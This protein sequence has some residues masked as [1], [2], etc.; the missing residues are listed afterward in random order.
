MSTEISLIISIISLVISLFS[1]A[2]S[3]LWI[4]LNFFYK[5]K[6]YVFCPNLIVYFEFNEKDQVSYFHIPLSIINK[7]SRIIIIN[8]MILYLI[9]D[10][11]GM[12]STLVAKKEKTEW[13]FK[14][15]SDLGTYIKENMIVPFEIQKFSTI[16]E[17]FT[18]FNIKLASNIINLKTLK[19][20]YICL[21]VCYNI[22]KTKNFFWK[23]TPEEAIMKEFDIQKPFGFQVINLFHEK[24]IDI[25][26]KTEVK[27]IKSIINKIKSKPKFILI[28]PTAK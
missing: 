9:S 2:G 12:M 24:Q 25:A 4:Y 15:G 14:D 13:A 11:K 7:G 21:E 28:E 18:F 27:E 10:N 3:F 26:N 19:S 1:L 5:R 23:L 8:S 20:A 16:S 22:N 6:P 17:T